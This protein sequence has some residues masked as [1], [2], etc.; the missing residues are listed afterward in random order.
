MKEIIEKSKYLILIAVFSSLI[1]SAAG[2]VWGFIKTLS[3]IINFMLS[4][5]KDP[6]A[7]IALIEIMDI[8]LIATVLFIFAM[9]MY[10]LFIES[11]KLP[12]WL[13][14][15]NLHDLKA[16]LNSVIILVMGITFLKHL[17][18][19]TDPQAAIPVMVVNACS[20]KVTNSHFS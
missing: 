14:I 11:I 10:E 20:R 12:E 8:F 7:A 5:G 17:V 3:I 1:A 4:Y 16:K 19:W 13:I 9:G 15:N 18:E 2:F 6:L